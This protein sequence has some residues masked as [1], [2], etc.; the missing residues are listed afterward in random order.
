MSRAFVA[1]AAC[2]FGCLC[3]G[4][5]FS[6]EKSELKARLLNIEQSL[7]AW[8]LPGAKKELAELE[9]GDVSDLHEADAYYRGRIAFEEGDYPH[10]ISSLTEAG[11]KDKPGSY[12]RLA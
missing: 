10:A 6:A 7:E 2:V 12:L 9:H 11:L 3:A 1:Q 4:L 5:A 8:D